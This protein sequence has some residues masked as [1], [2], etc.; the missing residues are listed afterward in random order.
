MSP[1]FALLSL[2]SLL[3]AT[4][5]VACQA[6]PAAGPSV[7]LGEPSGALP[8]DHP[9]VDF[10]TGGSGGGGGS[11]S[12]S[13]GAR[14]LS[15]AQLK[16]SIPVV[17]GTDTTG[18]PVSWK[19]GKVD[20][21][22]ARAAALGVANFTSV[23]EEN[24]EPSP[25]YLKFMSDMARDVC[26]RAIAADAVRSQASERVLERF[27]GLTDT[28]S[29][30]QAAVDQNLKYLKLIFHGVKVPDADDGPIAPLRTLFDAT[31]KGAAGTS[32]ITESHVREGWRAVCVALLT[33]PEF[34]LY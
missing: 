11:S 6:K 3:A 24:L 30:N 22:D 2:L 14:R 29:Q 26:N 32:A 27:V 31:V 23:S 28:V 10:G 8:L 21:F 19:V 9:P 20:G 33:A 16:A 12:A 15:V 7:S 25:L 13:A 34:H 1:R 18:S 4:S 17:L 5:L